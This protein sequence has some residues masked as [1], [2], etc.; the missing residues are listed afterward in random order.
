MAISPLLIEL[1]I[2]GSTT[3]DPKSM[4]AGDKRRRRARRALTFKVAVLEFI[5]T[6]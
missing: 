4:C 6:K 3:A 5:A 2:L 1:Y